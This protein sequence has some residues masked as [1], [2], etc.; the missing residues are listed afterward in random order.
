GF[1]HHVELV[2]QTLRQGLE[3]ALGSGPISGKQKIA[4][5]VPA[6]HLAQ[7]IELDEAAGVLGGGSVVAGG[8]LVV[9]H[10]L[11]RL[12]RPAAQ[13][14]PPKERPFIELRA[15]AGRE[16]LEKIAEIV[17]ASPLELALVAGLLEELSI[18][19]QIDSRRPPNGRPVGGENVAGHE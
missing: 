9:H 6:I 5:E 14:F 10:A 18:H 4:D 15:A 7:W 12:N 8:I 13:G 1:R 19:P 16:T 2:A 17:A 3:T 11:Q